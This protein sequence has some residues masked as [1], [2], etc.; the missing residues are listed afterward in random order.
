[1]DGSLN[2]IIIE[3]ESTP[4][5]LTHAWGEIM[6]QYSEAVGT[7]EHRYHLQLLKEVCMIEWRYNTIHLLILEL[8]NTYVQQFAALLN[9]LLLTSFIFDVKDAEAYDK[10]LDRCHNR[11]KGI[12]M[13]LDL[14]T[15]KLTQL[16]A[17][18]GAKGVVSKPTRAY[19]DNTLISLSDHA[20]FHLTTQI[21]TSEFCIRL[22][23]LIEFIDSQ[24]HK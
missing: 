14:K 21:T 2:A 3:G 17:K 9:K 12:K 8:R 13:D 20:G 19:F 10:M 18:L 7:V 16:Q 4:E 15:M 11:S 24:K 6:E 22:K 1:V 23:R 5:D